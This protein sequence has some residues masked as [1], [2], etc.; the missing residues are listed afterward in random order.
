MESIISASMFFSLELA[1]QNNSMAFSQNA[2]LL[3]TLTD[4]SLHAA[5]IDFAKTFDIRFHMINFY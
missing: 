3:E 4:F 2:L 1:Y 5:Y